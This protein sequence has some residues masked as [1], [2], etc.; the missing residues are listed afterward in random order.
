MRGPRLHVTCNIG[1]VGLICRTKDIYTEAP[2]WI[3]SS[4]PLCLISMS[5]CN[6]S[7][8]LTFFLH[9]VQD[10]SMI[11]E[12]LFFC[13]ISTTHRRLRANFSV[14]MACRCVRTG[15]QPLVTYIPLFTAPCA[16]RVLS[17]DRQTISVRRARLCQGQGGEPFSLPL[18]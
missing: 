5:F 2:G 7:V 12:A 9:H 18:R 16:Y 8:D 14:N 11:H 15:T 6:D 4:L 1:G 3:K 13:F 10:W 17:L